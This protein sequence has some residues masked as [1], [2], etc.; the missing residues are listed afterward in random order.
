MNTCVN[1]EAKG[2]S[3]ALMTMMIVVLSLS[4]SLCLYISIIII[5]LIHMCTLID[6]ALMMPLCEAPPPHQ[7]KGTTM[8]R[9]HKTTHHNIITYPSRKKKGCSSC[10]A[11]HL[12]FV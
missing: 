6:D 7:N 11:S 12:L 10:K 8:K 2:V 1:I 9:M 3:S 4:L 5:M